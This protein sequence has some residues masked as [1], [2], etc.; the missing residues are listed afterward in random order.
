[1][2]LPL[3]VDL[4]INAVNGSSIDDYDSGLTNCIVKKKSG[5]IIVTQRPSINLF[6]DASDSVADARGRAIYFWG[7]SG[8]RYIVNNNKIYKDSQANAAL[9][10]ITAG[11]KK[12]R[13]VELGSYLVL[14]DTENNQGWTITAADVLAEIADTDFPPKQIPA[15]NLAYGAAVLDEYLVVL[16]VNGDLY[17]CDL[18]DPTSWNALDYLNAERYPDGGTFIGRHHDDIIAIGPRS[19]EIF[20]DASN[21]TGSPLARRQDIAYTVGSNLGESFWEVGDLLFFIGTNDAGE[22]GVYKL[23]NY[24][25]VKISPD[26]LDTF[27]SQ[28][29]VQNGYGCDGSGFSAG[30]HHLYTLTLFTTPS[31]KSPERTLVYDDA[32]GLWYPAF[33]TAI[34]GHSHFPIVDWTVRSD[35]ATKIGEGILSNGDLIA[36]NHN[37]IP[38]DTKQGGNY[39]ADNY[40]QDQ[41]VS[42]VSSDGTAIPVTI[43]VGQQDFGT[44]REKLCPRIDM[45]G[46]RAKESQTLTLKWSNNNN[47][48]FATATGRSFDHSK[49]RPIRNCGKF[50]RRN[51]QLEHSSTESLELEALDIELEELSG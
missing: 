41:Y 49:R 48:G 1:M 5:R 33:T 8:H 38:Q 18:N 21:T 45:V 40:V 51:F 10:T 47:D 35:T 30:G 13:F 20:Y 24:G 7:T 42:S 39:V 9:G 11:T 34:A 15:V 46:D 28:A 2:R 26:D 43:R 25:L 36:P 44:S 27:L 17:N 16:D 32:A 19:I 6:E 3:A 50:E 29:I 12:C 22:L 23:V 14:I 4:K 31:D 37:L